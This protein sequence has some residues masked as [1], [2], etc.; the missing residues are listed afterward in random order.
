VPGGQFARPALVTWRGIAGEATKATWTEDINR[1][2]HTNELGARRTHEGW[3]VES[4]GL[5]SSSA[6]VR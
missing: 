3:D 5:S 6:A 2:Q 4:S 1:C